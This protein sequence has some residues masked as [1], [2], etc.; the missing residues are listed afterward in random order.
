M[1][2]NGCISPQRQLCLCRGKSFLRRPHW[3][4]MG[5]LRL[6]ELQENKATAGCGKSCNPPSAHAAGAFPS[7]MSLRTFKVLKFKK[8]TQET[9]S[10]GKKMCFVSVLFCPPR[11]GYGRAGTGLTA[12]ARWRQGPPGPAARPRG[13]GQAGRGGAR[14]GRG[15]RTPVSGL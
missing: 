10:W 2:G 8:N 11:H 9:H 12:A 15:C 14:R 4:Q 7:R 6:V 5:T 13:R 1:C 3:I